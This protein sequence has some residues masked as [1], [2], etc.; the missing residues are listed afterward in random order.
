MCRGNRGG[1]VKERGEIEGWKERENR[2]EIG[3]R[4]EQRK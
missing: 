4:G 3:E 1:V 2:E